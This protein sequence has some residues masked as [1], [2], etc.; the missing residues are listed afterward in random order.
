MNFSM[1]TLCATF[2]A[3][4]LALLSSLPAM[5]IE[6]P[7]YKVLKKEGQFE[8]REYSSFVV[9]EI[10]VEANYKEAGN[11]AFRPLFRYISG[12]N[13]AATKIEMTVPVTQEAVGSKIEM[14]AP[15]TQQA[16]G[17]PGRHVVSFVLPARFS[18]ANAPAPRD[19]A[20][21][22]REVQART[23]A[24]LDFSGAWGLNDVPRFE[25]ELEAWVRQAGLKVMGRPQMARYNAPMVPWFMRRNEILLDV[26]SVQ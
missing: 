19:P 4:A 9:V 1:R 26:A 8:L 3:C 22:L 17:T 25:A 6:E 10:E 11:L 5:A 21:R 20:V 24:V 23:V 12:E 16:S 7:A 15:V 14:T 2:A 18:M 13:T